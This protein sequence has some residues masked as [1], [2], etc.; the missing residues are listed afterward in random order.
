MPRGVLPTPTVVIWVLFAR[1]KTR[2]RPFSSTE[3][4]FVPSGCTTE[5]IDVPIPVIVDT[6]VLTDTPLDAG[7]VLPATSDTESLA[8]RNITVP[9]PQFVTVTV[10]VVP[11]CVP[12]T[13]ILQ[14]CAVP[15]LLISD[16]VNPVIGSFA[17]NV[18]VNVE[19]LVRVPL[20]CVNDI[21]GAPGVASTKRDAAVT[22]AVGPVL[23]GPSTTLFAANCNA[24]VPSPQPDTDTLMTVPVDA[25]GAN[26]QFGAVPV[27]E[28]SPAAKPEM[29][30]ENVR[31]N[32]DAA[33]DKGPAGTVVKFAVGAV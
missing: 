16:A 7:P 11:G 18:K 3:Y 12:L 4:S 26:T 8:K 21:T 14:F 29:A 6:T 13:A 22:A 20:L 28:K 9:S 33:D 31:V 10:K 19:L 32:V 23:P 2:T 5:Y 15:T 25:A 1:L 24:R 17:V 27:L 30:S